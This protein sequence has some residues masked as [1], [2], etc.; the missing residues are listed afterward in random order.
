MAP[1]VYTPPVGTYTA[2][3]TTT[4]SGTDTE[5]EFSSIPSGYRDLILTYDV[6]LSADAGL[7]LRV[8]GD[9]GS[10]YS[11]V[12][13]YSRLPSGT[14]LSAASATDSAAYLAVS[15]YTEF[16][17][18]LSILDY[19]ATDKHKTMLSRINNYGD[20]VVMGSHRWASLSQINSIQFYPFNTSF[21]AGSTASLFGIEA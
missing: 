18:E 8:N 7:H 5:I 3:A 9:T 21:A 15:G 11:V 19:S 2:L 1:T 17:G 16:W 6:K 14:P 10:N 13:A 12:Y 20:Y 4:L